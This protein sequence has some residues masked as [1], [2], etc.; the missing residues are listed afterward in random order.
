MPLIT[1]G[2]LEENWPHLLRFLVERGVLCIAIIQ[3]GESERER[4][5]LPLQIKLLFSF[6]TQI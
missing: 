6:E 3:Y 4:E 5:S 2:A 1:F